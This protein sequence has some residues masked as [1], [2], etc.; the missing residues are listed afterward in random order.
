VGA[1][2]GEQHN[3]GERAYHADGENVL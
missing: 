3:G 2:E 1:D